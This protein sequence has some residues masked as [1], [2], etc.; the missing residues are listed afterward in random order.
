VFGP[1]NWML[2]LISRQSVLILTLV[3][4]G[5]HESLLM[6]RIVT[7]LWIQSGLILGAASLW[8]FLLLGLSWARYLPRNRKA[9][10]TIRMITTASSR[11]K[12]RV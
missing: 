6:G 1:D 2:I 7:A 4:T 8:R 9:R 3:R 10:S 5:A 11:T 12:L